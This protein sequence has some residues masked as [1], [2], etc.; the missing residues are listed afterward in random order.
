LMVSGLAFMVF[1]F[2]TGIFNGAAEQVWGPI[3]RHL[4][5]LIPLGPLPAPPARDGPAEAAREGPDPIPNEPAARRRQP[6]PDPAEVAAR[7]LEQ[8]RQADR[9]WLMAQFRRAEH[10]LLLF[11]ASLVPGV[12]ERHIAA[13][14]ME[15]NAA[16]AERQRIIQAAEAVDA[17]ENAAENTEN[18]EN[19]REAAVAAVEN[20][21]QVRENRETQQDNAAPVQPLI[22]V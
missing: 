8:R 9:G 3:R 1:L 22:E 6:E 14:E 7:L 12:G 18:T 5:G 17:T 13:R 15:A 11:L 10:A 19:S 20:A 21:G 4:E 2:N 16:E